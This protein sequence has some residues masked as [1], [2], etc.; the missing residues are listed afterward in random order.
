MILYIDGL[1]KTGKTT[2]AMAWCREH[3]A[4][5]IHVP[6]PTDVPPLHVGDF[7]LGTSMGVIAA[8]RGAGVDFV[9]NRSF[10]SELVYGPLLGRGYDITKAQWWAKQVPEDAYFVYVILPYVDYLDRVDH[11]KEEDQHFFTEQ[12]WMERGF[13]YLQ[14]FGDLGFGLGTRTLVV[15]G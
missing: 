2:L 14:L 10:I 1:D 9:V 3:H 6:Y 8:Y 7:F 4:A 11:S 12:E 13:T 15:S 5:H